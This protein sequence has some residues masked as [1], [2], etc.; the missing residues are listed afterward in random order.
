MAEQKFDCSYMPHYYTPHHEVLSVMVDHGISTNSTVQKQ[1]D[2]RRMSSVAC[3]LDRA[4][5][6]VE[7]LHSHIAGFQEDLSHLVV[8]HEARCVE[9]CRV[10]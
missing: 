5:P 1:L 7:C 4:E 2:H 10:P 8:S 3:L 6:S 9:S